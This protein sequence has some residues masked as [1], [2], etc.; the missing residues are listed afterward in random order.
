MPTPEPTSVTSSAYLLYDFAPF[1][2]VAMAIN[3]VSSF[4]TAI[5]YKAV[6]NFD[7]HRDDLVAELNAVYTSGNCSD[8][9]PVI[10]FNEEAAGYK[11]K[12]SFLSKVATCIG[13]FLVLSQ[14]LLLAIIGFAP[15]FS[16][17][18]FEAVSMVFLSLVPSTLFRVI[19]AFYSN[20]SVKKLEK[21]SETIKRSAKAALNDNEKAAY[22]V[23]LSGGN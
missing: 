9:D 3:F 5:R 19:G 11:K 18:L 2:S 1:L 14:F 17:T 12:L 16:L 23:Q 22:D 20:S 8:S 21:T 6:N 13:V 15:Q 7:R 4:W 10:A